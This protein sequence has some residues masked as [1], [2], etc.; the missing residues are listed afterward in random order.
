[1][2]F[3]TPFAEWGERRLPRTPSKK[4][5]AEKGVLVVLYVLESGILLF[6]PLAYQM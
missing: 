3:G 1:M 4:G 2:L 6:E 5:T